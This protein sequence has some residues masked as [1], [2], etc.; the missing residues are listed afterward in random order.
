MSTLRRLKYLMYNWMQTGNSY[1][2]RCRYNPFLPHPF[3]PLRINCHL[4][5]TPMLALR[6][7]E[8]V[9][10]IW[11][12]IPNRIQHIHFRL[13]SYA[14]GGIL[15][16]HSRPNLRDWFDTTTFTKH[17]TFRQRATECLRRTVST[18]NLSFRS[19]CLHHLKCDKTQIISQRLGTYHQEAAI[20]LLNGVSAQEDQSLSYTLLPKET[21]PAWAK[22]LIRLHLLVVYVGFHFIVYYVKS[23]ANSCWYP[24]APTSNLDGVLRRHSMLLWL[25]IMVHV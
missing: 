19:A 13:L 5:L 17:Y 23:V 18:D 1:F 10:V 2:V 20:I 11:F 7:H 25:L 15:S 24:Q 3:T 16:W 12:E 22:Q 6:L 4:L 21:K 14:L 8:E 9:D